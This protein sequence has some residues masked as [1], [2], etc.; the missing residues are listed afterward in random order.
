MAQKH[1]ITYDLTKEDAFIAYLPNKK[2]KFTKTNHGLYMSKPNIKKSQNIN[3]QLVNTINKNKALYTHCQFERAK[4]VR[5]LY[6]A[7]RTLL[8]KDFKAI[9]QIY[10]ITNNLI[11]IKDI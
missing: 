6:H 10:M 8:S 11:T 5:D 7:L 1:Q 2:V 4:N 3:F 9:L